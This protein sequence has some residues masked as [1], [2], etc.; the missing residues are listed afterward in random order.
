[1]RMTNLRTLREAAKLSRDGL[2]RI[3]GV[4]SKTIE[5]HETGVANDTF[6]SIAMPIARALKVTLE[7]LFL[8]LPNG[9]R[10][11]DNLVI[12]LEPALATPGTP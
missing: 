6:V 7:T 12:P 11:K 3:S 5:A 10:I 8:D 9:L 1:M 2:A 4:S